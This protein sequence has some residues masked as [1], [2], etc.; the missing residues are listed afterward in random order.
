MQLAYLSYKESHAYYDTC[1]VYD[2]SDLVWWITQEYVA[3]SK[4]AHF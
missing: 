1:S 3:T 2:P 4:N